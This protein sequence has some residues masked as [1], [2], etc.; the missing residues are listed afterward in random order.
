MLCQGEASFKAPALVLTRCLC[1]AFAGITAG[2]TSQCLP[3]VTES[4]SYLFW[5]IQPHTKDLPA[6]VDIPGTEAIEVIGFQGKRGEVEG[7]S[8]KLHS[9]CEKTIQKLKM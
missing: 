6:E 2:E 9:C 4:L 5:M 8:Y 1:G 3:V 7:V